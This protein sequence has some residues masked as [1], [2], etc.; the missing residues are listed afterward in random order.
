MSPLGR[1]TISVPVAGEAT[2]PTVSAL[3]LS[4]PRPNPTAG[5]AEVAL[6]LP[7]AGDARVAVGDVLY[8]C[9]GAANRDPARWEEPD[10]V[11]VDRADAAHHVQFG[12]GVHHCLGSHLARLQAEVALGTL[13]ARLANVALAA[14]PVW[15][16]RMV[17]RGLQ[18]LPVTYRAG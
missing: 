14:E 16:E 6:T 3:T 12:S 11:R 17:I 18:S 4:A 1:R 2:T 9:V 8:P 15:S 13:V 5:T 7:A 10:L